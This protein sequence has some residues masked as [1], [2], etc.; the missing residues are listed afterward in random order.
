MGSLS[1]W[2]AV[3]FG[4][5]LAVVAAGA[6]DAQTSSPSGPSLVTRGAYLAKAADCMPCHTSAKDKQFAG[7][8]KLDTPFGAIFSPNITPDPDTGIGRWTYEDFKNAVHAGIRADGSYL[9]PVMT[10]DA[11]TLITEDDLK[12]L[13]AYFRSVPPIKQ[14]NRGNELNF[15]FNIRLALLPWRWLFFT[16]GYYK[17]NPAKGPQWNRGAY[18]VEALAHCSDCHT[19]RNFMGATIASKWLQ[20]ARIDQW[21][22]PNITA[23]AL[24]NVNKWDKARLIAFLR[25]GA[26]N[27]STALGPMQEVVHDSLSSLTE[28][29]LD[30]MA[31]FL[32]DLPPGAETPP[33][34]VADKLAPDVQARAAK[35]YS[36]NC[37]SCHQTDGKG[38]ANQIPPLAGNPAILAAKPFD[39]LAAVLQGVPA[40]NDIIAMPSFAG[41][42]GDQSVADLA[43]YLRTS[44]GNDAPP[45]ATPSMVAAWRSTLSLPVYASASAR[46]FDC[47]QVGQ[48]ASP[49]FT[50]SVIAGLGRE[51]AA[52]SV[53][54]AQLVADYQ[55]KNPNA[56]VTDTVNN[57][58]AAYCPVVA[59][60]AS[61]SNEGKSR[62]LER[63]AREIT[64][65]VTSMPLNE[66]EPDVGIIWATSLGASLLEH[67]PS[68]Q[69]ALTCPA[70]DKSGVPSS[71]LDAAAKL[72][73]K[74]DL[75]ISAQAATVQANN[76]AGQNP[77]AKL[78]DVA[79]AL[80]LAYCQGVS[81]LTGIDPAQKTAAITRYGEVV[82][83]ALQAKADA[84][85]PA[86]AAS[87]AAK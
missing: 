86:P 56:G 25:K 39:I 75:N 85:L 64:S 65:Y 26:G 10:Y 81:A 28:S 12:A 1:T 55:S 33:K 27:N 69:P 37:A 62:A 48:G 44:F 3:W 17:Q 54:Y 72:E 68:W 76:L 61:L 77:K 4:G 82:I 59:A 34:P 7:G 13:W 30:A 20:G 45:N 57:L 73:G 70:P 24:R 18:L 50:P 71:L 52:R 2:G 8:L 23:E 35:L 5:A 9:Y 19:P 22:A 43:N 42:L 40:R 47:P 11:F 6:A 60:N 79:N 31:T 38:I 32:L 63:F 53:S 21:Y 51:L 74:A 83:E 46:T 29:D 84:Q 66:S 49:S 80:I 67:D 36:D 41:S 78:A 15:P 58:I 14:Q 87:A 16:E